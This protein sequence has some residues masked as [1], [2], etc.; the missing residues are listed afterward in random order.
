MRAKLRASGRVSTLAGLGWGR[1]DD[2]D[3]ARMSM[4]HPRTGRPR[5]RVLTMRG[6]G[7][8]FGAV[9]ALTDVD[10][11]VNE[12]EVVA[13]VGDNGAGMSTLV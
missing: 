8:R 4:T 3:E 9:K 2:E 5:E 10:F 1:N 12:G 7:K 13:L 11:W 6:I